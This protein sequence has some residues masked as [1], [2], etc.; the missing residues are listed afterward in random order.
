MSVT[1]RIIFPHRIFGLE[2]KALWLE[3]TVAHS[4]FVHVV[5]G[6][7]HLPH[8]DRSLDLREVVWL[9]HFVKQHVANAWLPPG[10]GLASQ[11]S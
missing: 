7:N 6:T 8:G 1:F 4:V 3:V 9:D 11:F 5:H 2:E 10:V